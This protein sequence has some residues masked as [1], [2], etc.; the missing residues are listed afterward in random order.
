VNQTFS[1]FFM[2]AK[3]PYYNNGFGLFARATTPTPTT[4]TRARC[5]ATSTTT[6]PSGLRRR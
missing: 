4:T 2:S 3:A 5:S 1:N 6:S